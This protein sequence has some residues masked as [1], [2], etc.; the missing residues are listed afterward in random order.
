V[1]WLQ[2]NGSPVAPRAI[3]ALAV[4]LIGVGQPSVRATSPTRYS[5]LDARRGNGSDH[6]G[7]Q[8]TSDEKAPPFR[9]ANLL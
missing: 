2:G 9:E 4:E 5:M 6:A 8:R 1:A 7:R 3:S